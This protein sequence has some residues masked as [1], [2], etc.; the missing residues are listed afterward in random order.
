MEVKT[1]QVDIEGTFPVWFVL[2]TLIT[3]KFSMMSHKSEYDALSM[4]PILTPA[5]CAGSSSVL[6]ISFDFPNPFDYS[7]FL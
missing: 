7:K 5:C 2:P 6:S 1:K 4:N 3:P